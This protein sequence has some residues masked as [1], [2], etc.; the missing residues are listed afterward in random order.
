MLAFASHRAT[1]QLSA[2]FAV[3][4]KV[5]SIRAWQLQLKRYTCLPSLGWQGHVQDST[6]G[7]WLQSAVKE[8][9]HPKPRNFRA[10]T[11]AA[12][13]LGVHKWRTSRPCVHLPR[14]S[15]PSIQQMPNGGGPN[16]STSNSKAP[17]AAAAAAT[18]GAI[19]RFGTKTCKMT[20]GSTCSL[21]CYLSF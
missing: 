7:I 3:F 17:T 4:E 8:L 16:S 1:R 18:G 19:S 20:A 12:A 21:E 5:A 14:H 9:C 6:D 13:P 2:I 10:K 15:I 11:M